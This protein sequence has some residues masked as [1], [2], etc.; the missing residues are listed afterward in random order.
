MSSDP[1]TDSQ[2]Q[3]LLYLLVDIY[4]N[5]NIFNKKI[6]VYMTTKRVI[7]NFLHKCYNELRLLIILKTLEFLK[8]YNTK[9]KKKKSSMPLSRK[10]RPSITTFHKRKCVSMSGSVSDGV[11][12]IGPEPYLNEERFIFKKEGFSCK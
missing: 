9:K 7:F 1:L 4:N 12:H 10:K 5:L 8:R 2:K 6:K 3:R 11:S